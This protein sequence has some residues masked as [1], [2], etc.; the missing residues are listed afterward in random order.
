MDKFYAYLG[1]EGFNMRGFTIEE[2]I[3]DLKMTS[4]EAHEYIK[5]DTDN[6]NR[7]KISKNI[8]C[9]INGNSISEWD[10][11][12][13]SLLGIER[14]NLIQKKA[15]NPKEFNFNSIGILPDNFYSV[16]CGFDYKKYGILKQDIVIYYSLVSGRVS[17]MNKMD[18]YYEMK[19]FFNKKL[20][21]DGYL[22]E[23]IH[24]INDNFRVLK[25]ESSTVMASE[26]GNTIVLMVDKNSNITIKGVGNPLH[27]KITITTYT[28][29]VIFDEIVKIRVDDAIRYI[30]KQMGV[31]YE[32]TK[33]I[34]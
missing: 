12:L 13:L 18:L 27:T 20:T 33:N 28:G 5:E 23:D 31:K 15:T 30:A 34:F 6:E 29:T 19:E 26:N 4:D 9:W 16:D 14:F 25:F 22:E 8:L 24:E 3:Y 32:D 17:E 10:K 7:N 2:V 1:H 21:K 11:K